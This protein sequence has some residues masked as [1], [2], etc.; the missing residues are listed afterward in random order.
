MAF[1]ITDSCIACGAC[2]NNCP[3]GAIEAGD[4]YKISDACLEC[5]VCE[6]NC[7]VGAIV[8]K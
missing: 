2:A 1:V 6:S 3:A 8:S 7:P 5:G 4:I